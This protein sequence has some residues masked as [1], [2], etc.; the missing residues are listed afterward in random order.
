MSL[1][2]VLNPN[3][4]ECEIN[5]ENYVDKSDDE[6]C[7]LLI[8]EITFQEYRNCDTH[9][10][11]SRII[12]NWWI[13]GDESTFTNLSNEEKECNE[14]ISPFFKNEMDSTEKFPIY[15]V[16]QSTSAKIYNELNSIYN[17]VLNTHRQ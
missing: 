13:K 5:D 17:A 7:N 16:C 3:L 12:H 1:Q 9:I 11:S 14:I 4:D 15:F 8:T 6:V 2:R 10:M